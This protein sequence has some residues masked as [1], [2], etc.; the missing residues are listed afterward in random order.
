MNYASCT[1]IYIYVKHDTTST[2]IKSFH[3]TLTLLQLSD[4]PMIEQTVAVKPY[5]K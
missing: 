2:E 3:I 5:V 4:T 1:Y